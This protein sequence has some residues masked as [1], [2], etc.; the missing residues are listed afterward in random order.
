M[1]RLVL[2]AASLVLL[3]V[4][5]LCSFASGTGQ[6]PY[7]PIVTIEGVSGDGSVAS[8]LVDPFG[9]LGQ[10]PSGALF[11]DVDE[12]NWSLAPGSSIELAS[13]GA[14]LGRVTELELGVVGDPVVTLRFS[15]DS[16]DSST[17]WTISSTVVNFSAIASPLAYASAA[18]TVTSDSDGAVLTGQ[19]AGNKAY[20]ATYNGT[21]A[22]ADLVSSINAPGDD[23]VTG[24]ERSP[25]VS[26]WT[27]IA[28]PVSSIQSEFKFTLTAGDSASGTSRFEVVVPEPSGLAA[29]A[30]GLVSVG[31][32]IARKRR[33]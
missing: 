22:F 24:R 20:E 16:D 3:A 4:L 1:K 10:A 21:V 7:A 33:G 18:V 23:S 6:I 31:G 17:V 14:T 5:P 13:G 29:L 30:I 11:V 32:L 26:G 27:S 2:V 15:L 19:F 28:T 25:A 8:Y 12:F 9:V